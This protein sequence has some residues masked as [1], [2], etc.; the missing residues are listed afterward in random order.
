MAV[1]GLGTRDF[2]VKYCINV[3]LTVRLLL[4]VLNFFHYHLKVVLEKL[5][6][7]DTSWRNRI[8]L[9]HTNRSHVCLW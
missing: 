7:L 1:H 5:F 3:R 8:P 2:T 6:M 9:I 4:V